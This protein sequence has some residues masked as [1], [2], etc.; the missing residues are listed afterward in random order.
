MAEMLA[1][2]DFYFCR[3]FAFGLVFCNVVSLFLQILLSMTLHSGL[4]WGWGAA[5]NQETLQFI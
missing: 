2:F 3:W 4:S 5:I 1:S